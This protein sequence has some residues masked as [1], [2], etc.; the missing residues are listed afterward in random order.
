MPDQTSRPTYSPPTTV[1]LMATFSYGVPQFNLITLLRK[2]AKAKQMNCQ[3]REKVQQT[4]SRL[5]FT[6]NHSV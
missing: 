1:T 6:P 2:F 4:P 5:H 3:I